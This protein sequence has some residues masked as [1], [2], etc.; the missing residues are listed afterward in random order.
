MTSP[1]RR[2]AALGRAWGAGLLA[3]LDAGLVALAAIAWRAVARDE[4]TGRD[5]A[6]ISVLGGGAAIGVL[7]LLVVLAASL[8]ALRRS[9]TAGGLPGVGAG[10]AG[11]RLAAVLLAGVAVAVAAGLQAVAGL[12]ESCTLALAVLHAAIGLL[13]AVQTARATRRTR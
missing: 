7:V 4:V 6:A 3:V 9:P 8:R 5:V 10:L 12:A 2:R 1:Q 11:L 13:L